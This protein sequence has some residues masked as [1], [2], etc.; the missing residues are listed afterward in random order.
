MA[1]RPRYVMVHFNYFTISSKVNLTCYCY[2]LCFHRT[3]F[4]VFICQTLTFLP[5]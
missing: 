2:A 3:S 4:N 1:A 5:L